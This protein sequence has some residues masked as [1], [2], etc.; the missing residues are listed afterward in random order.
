MT[1][2]RCW[3]DG[4]LLGFDLETTGVDRFTDVPVS[5]ALVTVVSGVVQGRVAGL[6]D[7]GRPIPS[8]ATA[9]HGISTERA[10]AEGR[11]LA[12][13]VE[14][15]ADA[16]VEASGRGIPVAGMKLDF[17]LTI[18]DV[19]CR[20][21]D[22]RGLLTRGFSA[23]VLDALVLDRHFD[24]FR[25]G[26]RTLGDLCAHYDVVIENAHDAAADAEATLA[27]LAAMCRR[28]P[29]LAAQDVASLHQSQAAWHLDWATSYSE[30]RQGRGMAPLDPREFQWPLAAAAP[31]TG[32]APRPAG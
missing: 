28:Y 13:A 25:K 3:T 21:V 27:V 12:E 17:D 5:Y 24:R 1:P 18:L 11:P 30:W 29:E 20:A 7:P 32:P 31:A 15:L 16:L 23:P 8:E 10:H 22:G 6:V 9:V 14:F 19:Q 4:E 26:R 2:S